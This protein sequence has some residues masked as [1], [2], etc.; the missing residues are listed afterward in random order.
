MQSVEIYLSPHDPPLGRVPLEESIDHLENC[1][2]RHPG[3][4]GEYRSLLQRLEQLEK[5]DSS[6][7]KLMPSP[8]NRSERL[9]LQHLVSHLIF[10]NMGALHCRAC[11]GL[12]P[13]QKIIFEQFQRGKYGEKAASGK[14]FYCPQ[15]H[16]LFEHLDINI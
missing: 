14:R 10:T 6:I 16:L 8:S 3:L 13:A 15:Q 1:A 7:L 11:G 5:P 2:R 4:V 12:I 9:H